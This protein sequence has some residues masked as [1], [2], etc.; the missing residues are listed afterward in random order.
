MKA[1]V[2]EKKLELNLRD[3]DSNENGFM[4]PFENYHTIW[5]DII[6]YANSSAIKLHEKN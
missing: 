4:D 1:L 6:R 2:L 5:T 3:V